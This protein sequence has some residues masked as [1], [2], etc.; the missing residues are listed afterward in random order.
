MKLRA[1]LCAPISGPHL[2]SQAQLSCGRHTSQH[3]Q[4]ALWL[5][6]PLVAACLPACL[7]GVVAEADDQDYW[8]HASRDGNREKHYR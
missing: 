8:F 4:T 7:Q 2:T 5:F 3:T 1:S 6:F